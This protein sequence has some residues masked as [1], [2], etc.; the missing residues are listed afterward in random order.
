MREDGKM[1]V[2]GG[3]GEQGELKN[4]VYSFETSNNSWQR[5]E[6]AFDKQPL[7]RAGHSSVMLKQKMF[8]F[9]GKGSDCRK[10]NDLWV[11]DTQLATWH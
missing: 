5:E 8:V 6:S 3:F 9:G 4:D 10:F 2:F 11:Y 7:P 1:F